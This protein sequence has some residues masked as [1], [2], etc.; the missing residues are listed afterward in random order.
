[1]TEYGITKE[2]DSEGNRK[3][4]D[5]TFLFNNEEIT[6]QILPPTISQVEDLE[7]LEGK[8]DPSVSELMQTFGEFIV[9]PDVDEPTITEANAFAEGILDYIEGGTNL[10]EAAQEELE[11]R[12]DSGN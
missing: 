1:M 7:E 8:E 11:T 10:S 5:H 3:P 6:I 4:V 12:G 9:K 2:R